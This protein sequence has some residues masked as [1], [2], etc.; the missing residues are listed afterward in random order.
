MHE[1]FDSVCVLRSGVKVAVFFF[2]SAHLYIFVLEHLS[3]KPEND[4]ASIPFKNHLFRVSVAWV[5]FF[6]LMILG[7]DAWAQTDILTN[8]NEKR[9]SLNK[10]HMYILGAWGSGNIIYG[11][12]GRANTEGSRKYFHEMNVFWNIVNLGLAGAGLYSAY[13]STPDQFSLW[14]TYAEQQKLEKILL[15]NGALNVSY[16]LGGVLMQ[17]RAKRIEKNRDRWKGYGKSLVLQGAF[18]LAFDSMQFIV[19]NQ[20]QKEL[21]VLLEHLQFQ[22]NS[23]SLHFT[24]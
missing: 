2:T 13:S 11:L 6:A 18:L 9:I 22:G 12:I 10:R 20:A 24:F 14:E 5:L 17:E 16:I 4:M 8:I 15:V 3:I 21:K 23:V 19:H 7:N 1:R